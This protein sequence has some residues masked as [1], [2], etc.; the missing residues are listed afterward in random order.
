MSR[1]RIRE[2]FIELFDLQLSTGVL[3]E[4]IGEAGR[5]MAP[6]EASNIACRTALAA[7]LQSGAIKCQVIYL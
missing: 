2:F 6:L 7:A 5:A 4:T 3:D 1:A